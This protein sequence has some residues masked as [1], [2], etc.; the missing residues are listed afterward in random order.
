MTGF[1]TV[2]S[3]TFFITY[4][5]REFDDEKVLL[6]HQKAKHF[7]CHICYKKLFT[8]PG[9]HIHCMQV[10][11]EHVDK[12]PNAIKGRDS[13]EL[14]IYGMENVPEKDLIEHEKQKSSQTSNDFYDSDSDS[15]KSPP[16][17]SSSISNG[18]SAPPP[19]PPLPPPPPPPPPPQTQHISTPLLAHQ[20]QTNNSIMMQ[21]GMVNPMI[22]PYSSYSMNIGLINMGMNPMLMQHH[23]IMLGANMM[24]QQKPQQPPLPPPPPPPSTS[25]Q[26]SIS[27][28]PQLMLQKIEPLMSLS[29]MPTPSQL[30]KPLF[31]SASAMQTF[32]HLNSTSSTLSGLPRK[33]ENIPPG[34]ILVHPDEDISL[35]EYRARHKRYKRN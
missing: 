3:L 24:P 10:H 21:Q 30:N 33:I 27:T 32:P 11:K 35:E 13:I 8:G 4:C 29:P 17:Q 6:Q 16:N 19:L 1:F 14:E 26:S 20:M 22:M 15:E 31:P 9:L 34:T 5:N 2:Y 18:S 12:V 28:P 7:K 25:S 23:P